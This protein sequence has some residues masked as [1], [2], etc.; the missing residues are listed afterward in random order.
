M[1]T[2]GNFNARGR[3]CMASTRVRCYAED[4]VHTAAVSPAPTSIPPGPVALFT[5]RFWLACA[6]H[7]TG[8]LAGALYILF[9]LFIRS[10]GGN[11][12]LIGAFTGLAGAA[13]VA[14][15]FPLG[16]LLDTQGRRRVLMA[17]GA[18]HVVSWAGF[19][20]IDRLGAPFTAL[21]I[22]HGLAGG[23]LFAGYF[24]YA[25]DITP[26]ARRT[27]GIAMFGV[28]GM[29]TNGLSPALGEWLIAG[30]GF[31]AYF[32]TATA[33]AALSLL[34]SAL[35]PE[36]M[37]ARSAAH[38]ADRP[39]V[40]LSMRPLLFPLAITFVFAVAVNSV[41]T[42][43][44]PFAQSTGRGSVGSFFLAY[45]SAAVVVRVLGGR[46]PDRIG[47]RRV[48]IPALV[49][50]AAGVLWVAH[51][52]GRTALIAVGAVCGAGHGYAFPILNV[53]TM[54][55]VAAAHRGRAVSWF[56][57]MF[58]L[59]VTIANPILGAIADTAG[60]VT[61]YTVSGIALVGAAGAV[62]GK[63]AADGRRNH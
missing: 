61:M 38:R 50:T 36:T 37:P 23:S 9:P 20:W 31:D 46:L 54:E 12:F 30:P 13:A 2:A 35:L 41:F 57:A 42:F 51:A 11:D 15:R 19:A 4:P 62:W 7:F 5:P 18:V 6:V 24:T 22:L 63:A 21:V 47:P 33:L 8:A 48:L 25:S 17:A 52:D 32:L 10:L 53:L 29:L 34:L 43:L 59:G 27:E 55:Q 16:R 58:D 40:P 49:V 26:I 1:R 39:S 56:T 45:S 44:A 28:F 14:A 3:N 60:Y